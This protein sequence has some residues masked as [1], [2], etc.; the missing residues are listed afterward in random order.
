MKLTI[1][2]LKQVGLF[3]LKPIH[4]VSLMARVGIENLNYVIQFPIKLTI[5]KAVPIY[6]RVQSP[7]ITHSP[8]LQ[9]TVF[10]LETVPS[11]KLQLP[12]LRYSP[13]R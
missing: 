9:S 1:A 4:A 10:L 2:L 5:L 6:C 7:F 13:P 3:R 8:Q 12:V 11:S